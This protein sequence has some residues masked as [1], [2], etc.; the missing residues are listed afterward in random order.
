MKKTYSSRRF[1]LQ[2]I[3]LLQLAIL[4]VSYASPQD[5]SIVFV[6]IGPTLPAHLKT[7]LSQ[8]RLFNES[9]PIYLIANQ[10]ALIPKSDELDREGITGIPCETLR[11]TPVHSAFCN[12]IKFPPGFARY[13]SERF[14]YLYDFMEQYRRKN[15]FH[16]ENDN[17]LYVDLEELL[18]IFQANYPG[19]AATFD[20]DE[21]CIAGFMYIADA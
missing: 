4:S 18:P 20:N 12:S 19:I 16:L 3:F 17:M 10:E 8:A 5:Y 14:L 1:F 11:K 9:C 15:V 2:C 21:R 13:T 6:H 7:S